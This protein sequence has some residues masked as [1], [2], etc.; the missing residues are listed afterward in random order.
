MLRL[1]T[2]TQCGLL[3]TFLHIWIKILSRRRGRRHALNFVR[4]GCIVGVLVLFGVGVR[5]ESESDLEETH[6]YA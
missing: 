1:P 5:W 4:R 3:G 2:L 6:A